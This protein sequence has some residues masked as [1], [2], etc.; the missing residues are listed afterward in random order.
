MPYNDREY[1]KTYIST[2][3]STTVFTGRG[4]LG[5]VCVNTSAA[6]TI[7][8]IDGTTPFAVLKASIAEGTYLQGAQ[9]SK[10]LIIST[11]GS[12]DIT[13]LWTQG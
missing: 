5:G 2:S 8:L 4:N 11:A 7:T 13:I 1:Q 10:S 3:A 6:G 12:P 9:I